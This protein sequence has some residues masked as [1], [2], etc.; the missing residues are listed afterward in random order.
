MKNV[1]TI[2]LLL[3]FGLVLVVMGCKKSE[4]PI[5][6]E[7]QYEETSD[8]GLTDEGTLEVPASTEAAT[9]TTTAQNII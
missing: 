1:A 7:A 4:A 8:L 3:L 9:S 5:V 2:S 6:E